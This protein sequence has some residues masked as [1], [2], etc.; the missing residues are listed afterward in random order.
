[1]TAISK[2][3]LFNLIVLGSELSKAGNSFKAALCAGYLDKDGGSVNLINACEIA[4][5]KG[6]TVIFMYCCKNFI[7]DILVC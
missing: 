5:E 3:R 1:L 2:P 7:K 6:I 4:S